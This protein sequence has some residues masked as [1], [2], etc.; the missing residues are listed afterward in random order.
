MTSPSAGLVR[1]PCV[2]EF[3]ALMRFLEVC[4]GHRRHFFPEVYPHLYRPEPE[5]MA[6]GNVIDD[7]DGIA[8]HVG[9]YPISLNVGG[10]EVAVGGIGGVSTRPDCRSKGYMSTLL[11]HAICQMREEGYVVSALSGDRQRYSSFG[12]ER[13]GLVYPLR[14]DERSLKRA[15]VEEVTPAREVRPEDAMALVEALQATVPLVSIRPYLSHQLRKDSLR[16]W[17]VPDD[18]YALVQCPEP[19]D[20]ATILE[21]VSRRGREAELILTIMRETGAARV[22]WALSFCDTLR[23]DRLFP[24]VSHWSAETDWMYRIIDLRGLLQAYEPWLQARADALRD[25][26]VNICI[27]E[28]D[29][30]DRAAITV[31]GGKLAISSVCAHAPSLGLSPVS[32]VR[33]FFGGPGVCVAAG[34]PG[35][36]EALLPL[37]IHVPILDHV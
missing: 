30:Q 23:L 33:L 8:S 6:W 10:C 7:N 27:D 34:L 19:G 32:A 15:L 17:I 5:A 2:D 36:L 28:G 9:V 37:P 3:D 12:W 31:R 20:H 18:S 24:T 25:F 4:Y 29:R 1:T 22:T 35:A 16:A 26:S 21:L 13:G 14:F 11:Q